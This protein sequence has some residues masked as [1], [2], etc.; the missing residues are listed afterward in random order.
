MDNQIKSKD[1]KPLRELLLEEQS[2]KCKLCGDDLSKEEA[3]LDHCHKS[4]HIRGVIHRTCNVYLGKIE[5]NMA[6]CR[7]SEVRL[8]EVIKRLASYRN[9]LRLEIHPTFG[10]KRRRRRKRNAN[11]S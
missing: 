11:P 5:N 4:G 9:N 8:L 2:Y 6:R 1:I 3:V 7:I 10:K